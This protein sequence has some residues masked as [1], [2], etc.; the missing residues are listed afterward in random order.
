NYGIS[1]THPPGDLSG[2]L[3]SSVSCFIRVI[4]V[5]RGR[6][7]LPFLAATPG[8]ETP[9]KAGKQQLESF[10]FFQF[11]KYYPV[12]TTRLLLERFN[13]TGGI[14]Q[15]NL[16]R[17]ARGGK[18]ED[19]VDD[20][21]QDFFRNMSPCASDSAWTAARLRASSCRR[22]RVRERKVERRLA[23]A[24]R[25]DRVALHFQDLNDLPAQRRIVFDDQNF[26]RSFHKGASIGDKV[27]VKHVPSPDVETKSMV[28][29]WASTQ[30]L[31]T[32]SPSPL[33]SMPPTLRARKNAE[34]RRA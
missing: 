23:V 10:Q 31:T 12:R 14:R 5:I 27:T 11:T 22:R 30:R 18:L 4:R 19:V 34:K 29:R 3:V 25:H 17:L 24:R 8:R 15:R 33:P 16:H 9:D 32:A 6:F 26:S 20:L 28:P 13:A 2:R 7:E 21:A 1:V